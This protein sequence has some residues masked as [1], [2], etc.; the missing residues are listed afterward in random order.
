MRVN[1][2]IPTWVYDLLA[3]YGNAVIPPEVIDY[4][5]VSY[6]AELLTD[7]MG[8]PV[9]IKINKYQDLTKYGKPIIKKGYIAW[10]KK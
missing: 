3:Q 10:M 1:D 6:T 9:T 4:Y 2:V 7:I 5:G 8:K